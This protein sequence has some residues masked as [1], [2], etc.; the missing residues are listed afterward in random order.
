MR[1]V[2]STS[3]DLREEIA[4]GRF[5]EDL[6]HRLNVVPVRVPGLSERREDIPELVEYFIER[7]SDA[8]GLPRRRLADDALATLQVHAWPGNVRQLRN[9][10]ERMLILASGD[11]AEPI[12]AD[13]L[14]ARGGRRRTDRPVRAPSGSSPCRCATRARCSSGS[15]STPRSCASAATSRAPP[16]S[17][18]WSARPCTAS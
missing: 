15:I 1:V 10:V 4:A 12:T 3:R 2:S 8:T 6:F 5:R 9:N 18:A 14:P 16:P 11:P 7:I 17:S 13:M